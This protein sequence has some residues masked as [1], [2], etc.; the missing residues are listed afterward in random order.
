MQMR[1][2][3]YRL[4]P[5]AAQEAALDKACELH[6]R[7]YNAA[8]EERI[9]AWRKAGI[10]ISLHEQSASLTAI[11]KDDP[12]YAELP[13]KAL[14]HTLERLDLAFR[15]FFRRVKAGEKPGFPR[16]KSR[17]RFKGFGFRTHGD[18]ATFK[19]EADRHG[20]LRIKG[21]LGLITARG[22]PR[23]IGEIRT[24]EISRKAGRW[25][26][27]VSLECAPVRDCGEDVVALDWGVETLASCV[28]ASGESLDAENTRIGRKGARSIKT[29][30]RKLARQKRSSARRERTKIR[31][32]RAKMAEANRRKDRAHKLS[33]EIVARAHVVAFEALAIRNMTRSAKG[34]V[35]EPGRNIRQKAGLNRE[36]LDTAPAQLMSMIT[37][38]AEEAGSWLMEAPTRKLKPSQTCPA[39]G[40]QKKK[41]LSQRTHRCECGHT[42]RRDPAS[43]R[44]VLNWALKELAREPGMRGEM[45]LAVSAN[46]ETA[47]FAQA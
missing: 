10:S 44:V 36:V 25:F 15:A 7:L 16:F 3:K 21:I 40:R 41:T 2:A 13:R 32:A 6:R 22:K 12:V 47:T 38:K 34:T 9:D 18:G 42:E 28:F 14:L 20:K 46:R 1:K 27:T 31:L 4:Y 43:A 35:E 29:I 5:N 17:D 26:L 23:T 24:L 39:C 33:A 45:A 37:Y 11:R 19:P 30:S 8:L